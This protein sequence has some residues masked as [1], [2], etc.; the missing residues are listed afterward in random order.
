MSNFEYT[1]IQILHRVIFKV[2]MFVQPSAPQMNAGG[3]GMM[4][5]MSSI[6]IPTSTVEV[7]VRC[8][9]LEDRD[10]MS[11]SDPLCVVFQKMGNTAANSKWYEIRRTEMIIDSLN[12][13]WQKKFVLS[14]NFEV[15]QL[16]KF[17]IYDSDSSSTILNQH[18]F[19]GRCEVALGQVISSQ[20]RQYVSV[21]KDV[22]IISTGST[23]K[24]KIYITAEELIANKEVATF[25]VCGVKLDK[26]DFFGKSDPF[27]VIYKES[28]N[29]QWVVV[30]KTEVIK[31]TLNPNWKPFILPLNQ[32]CNGDYERKLKFE[33]TDWDSDGSHDYIGSFVTKM[34]SLKMAPIEKT[35]FKCIN[36]KK[37][38][39]TGYENSGILVIKKCNIKIDP[40][41]IDYI[42]GGT[43]MIFSIAVD[44][45]ASNGD[46]SDHRSLHFMN[47]Q[48]MENQYTTAIRSV[49]EIVQD[50]DSDKQFPA[51]GFG[52]RIPPT[53]HV[54]HEF[55]LNL[56]QDNNPYC[57][58]V[59]GLLQAYR[60]SLQNVKLHGPTYFSPV[61]NH[62]ANFARAYQANGSQYFV[63]LI[64]TDGIINDLDATLASI[65]A[66]SDLPMS[67]I[68]IGVGDEDFSAMEDLYSDDKLLRANGRVARR[69]I[70][71]FV[72][73]RKFL[74]YHGVG[75]MTWNK[76]AL[77]KEVLAEVPKQVVSWMTKRGI[78]PNATQQQMPN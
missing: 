17:E 57:L 50:Y 67:I 32:L 9:D 60:H 16:M 72:E 43:S 11:K 49:G 4:P 68:I 28:P 21:L 37:K 75:Q 34:S 10:V 78:K 7:S 69:D 51:L 12:P 76:E 35:E 44:F 62:V 61:I 27:L 8:T 55:F 5:P 6:D 58:G 70:V 41:F 2:K 56:S 77:A 3:A 63:L 42:Q 36:E 14:Y 46:P 20:G 19:L 13:Q 66:A 40:S 64:L 15:R 31:N 65:I 52:A 74:S 1:Q 38:G 18:D 73:L 25:E 29:G 33:V 47:P 23:S 45:T 48:N 54:S 59:D 39:K 22:P 26:K 71:Q 30:H 53:G 24:G